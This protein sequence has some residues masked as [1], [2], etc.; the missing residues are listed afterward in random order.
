MAISVNER[1]LIDGDCFKCRREKY[2]KE[3]CKKH[4][5]RI[6]A[7]VTEAVNKVMPAIGIMREAMGKL[8][9]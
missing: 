8:S 9:Y 2:C 4:K 5:I 3:Q 1:W 7:E 6:D